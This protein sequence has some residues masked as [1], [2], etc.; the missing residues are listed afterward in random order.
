MKRI[1]APEVTL[2]YLTTERGWWPAEM[3]ALRSLAPLA[4]FAQLHEDTDAR[5]FRDAMRERIATLSPPSRPHRKAGLLRGILKELAE[6][7]GFDGRERA[8]PLCDRWEG[9]A[10][11]S[12]EFDRQQLEQQVEAARMRRA[13]HFGRAWAA[14]AKTLKSSVSRVLHRDRSTSR[15]DM[16]IPHQTSEA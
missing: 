14:T 2:R 1:D 9:S 4:A 12:P 10:K 15:T 8:A 11:V 6:A 5:G 13:R 16:P 7:H 3:T